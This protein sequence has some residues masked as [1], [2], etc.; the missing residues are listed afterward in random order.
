M[1][2]TVF[3]AAGGEVT[4]SAYLVET[5]RAAV[6]VE[7]GMFQGKN[8][9]GE[10]NRSLPRSLHGASLAA[11]LLTH[12]HLDHTGRLPLL[13]KEGYRG[14]VY[15]TPATGEITG[16]ILRDSAHLQEHDAER[17]S[18][19]RARAGDPPVAPLYTLRDAERILGDFAPAPYRE[20]IEVAPG[21]RA[22]FI[23]AGHILGSS[24]IQLLADEDGRETRVVFSGDL[25][26][27][28]AP[29]LRDFESFHDADLVVMESTYGDR[30]HRPF[31]ETV[32]QFIA[33]M[34]KAIEGK[35]KI[36]VPTF[37]VGRA[38][39][40]LALLAWIFR[41]GRVEPFPVF[42]DSPM[43]VEATEIYRRHPELFDEELRGYIREKVLRD[44]LK[45]LRATVRTEE[46]MAINDRPGPCLVLAGSGMCTGGRIL[47][48]LKH[49]L[50]KP[51]TH[52]VIVGYQ[53]RGTLGRLLVEG[54]RKVTIFGEPI[55]VNARI[56]TLGGFSSHAGQR[57]L[58]AWFDALAP[59]RPRL[60]LTHGEDH[61][62]EALAARIRE[63][64]GIEALLV[65][66]GA[67]V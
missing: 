15:A 44:D 20:P 8:G 67:T 13:A 33:I 27:R 2:V 29:I 18:R 65:E 11:V 31:G 41:S 61:A 59:A 45:T 40:L 26:P 7:C 58:L 35:G 42:L 60:V 23:E 16:L 30:N 51:E 66:E 38:Q 24:S 50:W 6:L 54:S 17:L 36:L 9:L 39:T 10:R 62:R 55:A 28:G 19:R 46:S 56:H 32:E 34:E 63:R 4:G 22:R 21:L 12:G 64:F 43:A 48:H 1:R 52:V 37:A 57:D 47:H 14:P 5:A 25:G 3:G 53:G 49:N